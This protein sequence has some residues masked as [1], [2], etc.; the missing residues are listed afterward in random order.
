MSL[1]TP[2]LY[3]YGSFQTQF[4]L[5]PPPSMAVLILTSMSKPTL[6]VL[7]LCKLPCFKTSLLFRTTGVCAPIL[8]ILHFSGAGV[9]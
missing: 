2:N 9:P 3:N 4:C 7:K 6:R 5:E 1:K 8:K